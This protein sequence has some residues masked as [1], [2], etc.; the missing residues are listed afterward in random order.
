M[1]SVLEE[2]DDGLGQGVVVTVSDAADRW[3]D[4]RLSQSLRVADR[5]ILPAAIAVVHQAVGL[6]ILAFTDRLC[7]RIECEAAA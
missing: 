1:T 3:F 2:A 5:Q 7:E 6:L 4:A